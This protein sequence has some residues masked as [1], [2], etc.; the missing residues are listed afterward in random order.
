[1][2]EN[3]DFVSEEE[4]P[5]CA[6]TTGVS[7]KESGHESSSEPSVAVETQ[8]GDWPLRAES[9]NPKIARFDETEELVNLH[10]R[11]IRVHGIGADGSCTCLK[12][13]SN[14]NEIA[15]HPVDGGWQ[16]TTMESNPD[17]LYSNPD[18]NVGVF[19]KPSGFF[20]IDIDPRSGGFESMEKFAALV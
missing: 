12:S 14:V 1:M 2:S 7:D 20:V 9:D 8:D 6:N 15:K 4:T 18:Y 3:E 17:W 13:H 11:L 5:E 16:E 10:W 19:C